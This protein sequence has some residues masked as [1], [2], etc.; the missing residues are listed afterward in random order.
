[1]ATVS[2]DDGLV[3]TITELA[4]AEVEGRKHFGDGLQSVVLQALMRKGLP[5][6]QT[7]ALARSYLIEGVM[8]RDTI[9]CAS[10]GADAEW[11]AGVLTVDVRRLALVNDVLGM[12]GGERILAL[13]ADGVR[14]FSGPAPVVRI[15]GDAFAAVYVPPREHPFDEGTAERLSASLVALVKER[16]PELAE[17]GVEPAFTVSALDLVIERPFHWRVLG[18]LVWAEAERANVAAR[19]GNA[20]GL[21]RRRLHLDGHVG[22]HSS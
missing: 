16:M 18:P 1:M 12:Q 3:E 7:G 22:T 15:H 10:L 21:Q 14:A 4:P 8:L 6:P 11:C 2:I 20:T 13:V 19:T 5:D 9:D 17:H